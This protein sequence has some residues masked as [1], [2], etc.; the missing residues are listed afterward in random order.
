MLICDY[1]IGGVGLNN[2]IK[3]LRK[4]VNLTQDEFGK[5]LGISNTAI[6]KIEKGENNVSEQNIISICREFNVNENWL[7]TGEGGDDNMFVKVT[8]YEKAYNRFG[9]I[10][11][12]SSPSKKATLSLLLELLYTVPD[13]KWEVIMKQFEEI[14]KEG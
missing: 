11:E 12:N 3:E 7:R 14:K 6:S 9:Y 10:M 8:P 5:R 4:A 13:D 2:R 1:Q